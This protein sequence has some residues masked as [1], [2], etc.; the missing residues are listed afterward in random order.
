MWFYEEIW[1]VIP[2]LSQL[3]NLPGVMPNIQPRKII[4]SALGF[5][6]LLLKPLIWS[7]S[8]D[9]GIDNSVMPGVP[10][11]ILLKDRADP[12]QMPYLKILLEKK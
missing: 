3:L 5:L 10:L 6:N 2:K 7:Y 1:K 9:L 8:V 4:F 11:D 12:G